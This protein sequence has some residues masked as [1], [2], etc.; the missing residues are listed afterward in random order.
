MGQGPENQVRGGRRLRDWDYATS[1]GTDQ[2][3]HAVALLLGP[4]SEWQSLQWRLGATGGE[5]DVLDL[6]AQLGQVEVLP[7]RT[8]PLAHEDSGVCS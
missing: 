1:P 3:I 2:W 5:A 7:T 4:E 8:W 6:C